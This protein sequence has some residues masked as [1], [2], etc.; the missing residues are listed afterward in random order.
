MIAAQSWSDAEVLG[1]VG[2]VLFFFA[3]L[4]ALVAVL[5]MALNQLAY[6]WEDRHPADTAHDL[7]ERCE[8]Y[9]FPVREVRRQRGDAA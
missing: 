9:T 2:F 1:A 8:L 3:C 5:G 4:F 6:W 7:A